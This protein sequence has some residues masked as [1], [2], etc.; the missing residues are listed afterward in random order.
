MKT[1]GNKQ[2]GDYTKACVLK[3]KEKTMSER[4]SCPNVESNN[5][6]CNCAN[7]DCDNH[8]ICCLCVLSHRNK[9]HL[10]ACLRHFE[11]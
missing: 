7:T 1:S 4:Q 2:A 6:N 9:D 10:P 3:R 8:G 5:A 11:N